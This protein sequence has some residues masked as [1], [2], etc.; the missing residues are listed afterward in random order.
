M[1]FSPCPRTDTFII[2]GFYLSLAMDFPGYYLGVVREG[3]VGLGRSKE[4]EAGLK[5]SWE[6]ERLLMSN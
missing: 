2:I 6:K 4:A 3:G 5:R 1:Q